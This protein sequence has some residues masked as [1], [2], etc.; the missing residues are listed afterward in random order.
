MDAAS[1]S[2]GVDLQNWGFTILKN[3]KENFGESYAHS[4]VRSVK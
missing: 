3:S 1:C 4:N 2:F